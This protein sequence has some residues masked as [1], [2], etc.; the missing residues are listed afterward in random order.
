M[1]S[2]S[3]RYFDIA[4]KKKGSFLAFLRPLIIITF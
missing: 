1:S 4:D 3:G 2:M